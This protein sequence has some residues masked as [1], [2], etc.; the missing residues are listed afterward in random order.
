M[1][2]KRQAIIFELLPRRGEKQRNPKKEN[3][4]RDRICAAAGAISAWGSNL[5]QLGKVLFS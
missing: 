1:L 2:S 3:C 4:R 5:G